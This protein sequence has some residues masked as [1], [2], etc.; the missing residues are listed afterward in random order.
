MSVVIGVACVF[1]AGIA[2]F[3]ILG[4]L[5]LLKEESAWVKPKKS[6]AAYFSAGA[7]VGIV[8]AVMLTVGVW[9]LV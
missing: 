6:P 1:L 2:G 5:F 8:F 3:F 9:C 4:S 7:M